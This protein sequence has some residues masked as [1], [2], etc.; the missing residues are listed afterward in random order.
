MTDYQGFPQTH[1]SLVRRAGAPDATARQEALAILLSRYQ[2][3]L[4]SYLRVV[5]Q[6]NEADADDLLQAFIADQVLG[7]ELLRRADQSRGRFRTLLLA[8]LNNFAIDRARAAQRRAADPLA[9]D[10]AAD[11]EMP[12]PHAAVEAEWARALVHEVLQAMRAE[13][14]RTGRRD[15][16]RVFESRVLAEIFGPQAAVTPYEQLAAELRLQTPAQAA[17]LLVTGKRMY[18]RLLRVAVAEY[19]PDPEDIDAEI[20]DLRRILAAVTPLGD[21]SSEAPGINDNKLDVE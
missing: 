6:M 3:A 17:N 15:V 2:P 4:R 19:E 8:S 10:S 11:E 9:S 7:N 20:A 16:W 13:C 1:W 21:D 5:R 14:E 18:A 12:G